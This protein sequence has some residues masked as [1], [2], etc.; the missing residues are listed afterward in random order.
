MRI[1]F[2]DSRE[3]AT[4]IVYPTQDPLE[5]E[6]ARPLFR[7]D[8]YTM[9][10]WYYFPDSYDTWVTGQSCGGGMDI[11]ETWQH[12]SVQERHEDRNVAV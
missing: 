9:L 4:H 7:R 8:K 2:T 11:S 1:R 5:E 3:K 10:H 6:Y 12:S